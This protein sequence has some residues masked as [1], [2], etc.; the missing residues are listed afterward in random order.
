M[1]QLGEMVAVGLVAESQ[2]DCP[3]HEGQHQ[4]DPEVKSVYREGNAE[5]LGKNLHAGSKPESST[6]VRGKGSPDDRYRS[7]QVS[8]DPDLDSEKAREVSILAGDADCIYPVA[9][10]AHHLIPGKAALGRAKALHKFLRKGE[11]CCN[12]GYSVDGNENGVW[13]PGLHAVNSNGL[14]LWS[15][16]VAKRS[17]PDKEDVRAVAGVK[18]R[19]RHE[20]EAA[21]GKALAKY[22]YKPLV[23]PTPGDA[24]AQAFRSDNLKWRY[25]QKSMAYLGARQFHDAHPAYSAK[26]QKH[27]GQVAARLAQLLERSKKPGSTQCPECKKRADAKPTPPIGLLGLLNKT[28]KWYRGRLVG[29]TRDSEYYTSSWC[30]P[31]ALVK[32]R[33]QRRG[34]P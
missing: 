20:L 15:S 2:V 4:C 3:F 8:P 28:S 22:A 30:G 1:T 6:V 13:L 33:K 32:P 12:L 25:V 19:M 31:L 23:G 26:V 21:A 11:F 18:A 9:F 5:A 7:N 10:A 17:L 14:N 29:R 24:G 34:R 27:L 16:R